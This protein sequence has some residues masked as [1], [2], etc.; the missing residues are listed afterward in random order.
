M[1]IAIVG[2][3][4]IAQVHAACIH[5]MKEHMFVACADIKID[6]AEEM[7][8]QYGCKA[9]S[10]YEEMLSNEEIDVVHICTPHYLHVPMIITGLKAGV[11]VFSEK[12][13]VMTREQYQELQTV[14]KHA[15][16]RLGICFQNRYNPSVARVQE[17]LKSG[18]AGTL[19][20]A[21]G[22]V[23]WMRNAPYYTEN[24]WRGTWE[25]EGGGALMNQS[26]HTLDLIQYLVAREPKEVDAVIANHH[27]KGVI[28]VEDTVSAYITY[29]DCTANFY[30]TNAYVA[31]PLP[32]I[33]LQCENMRIR[34][35]GDEVTCYV[36]GGQVNREMLEPIKAHGK[37]YWG[38]GHG[39]CIRDYYD[40][41]MTGRRFEQDLDG[42]KSTIEL[43][44]GIY[45]SAR[46]NHVVAIGG[47]QC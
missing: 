20:G 8:K 39:A 36:K 13:P 17:I 29:P 27:L 21:R 32:L 19:L 28:E 44:L 12:P 34:M 43:L 4:G 2:C 23:T 9:Y 30:A 3:G 15:D 10:D 26:V 45:E 38:A 37:S 47:T 42:L 5:E 33:E 11:N 40:C 25:T 18:E 16:K 6:R 1:K 46:Q 24:D 22:M 41:L 14:V 7:S 31:N 35:E